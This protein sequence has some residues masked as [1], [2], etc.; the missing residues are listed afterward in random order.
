[1]KLAISQMNSRAGNFAATV[2][3]MV[4]QSRIAQNA[5]ARCMLFPFCVL[6]G[7]S[8]GAWGENEAYVQ[9]LMLA[10]SRLAERLSVPAL[11]PVVFNVMGTSVNELFYIAG[12]RATPVRFPQEPEVAEGHV[13]AFAT[14]GPLA[15]QIGDVS[16][17][18]AFTRDDLDA[19]AEL[20]STFDLVVYFQTEG[21]CVDDP[22]SR[23]APAVA[24]GAY[25]RDASQLNAWFVAVGP[26]G[27]YDEC[28]YTGG[29]F[30]MAPWG[31]LAA[32][33]P[34]FEEDF[35]IVDLAL[36][37]EGPLQNAVQP[38]VVERYSFFWDALVASTRAY[39]QADGKNRAC[40]VALDGSLASAATATM[41]VDAV[42][43]TLVHP[44]IVDN[45]DAAALADARAL[46]RN[47][48]LEATELSLAELA[49]AAHSFA[50]NPEDVSVQESLIAARMSMFAAEHQAL[51][52]SC[53]D[54]TA[55][56]LELEP[57]GWSGG[58]FAPFGDVYRCDVRRLA[59]ARARRSSSVPSSS[60]SRQHAT[61]LVGANFAGT[62]EQQRINAIDAALLMHVEFSQGVES[63]IASGN[64]HI[65]VESLLERLRAC[66]VA[67]RSCPAFPAVSSR[68]VKEAALPVDFAW[69]DHVRGYR[70]RLE[71]EEAFRKLSAQA[72]ADEGE[73]RPQDIAERVNAIRDMLQDMAATDAFEAGDANAAPGDTNEYGTWGSELFSD[74]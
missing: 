33:F 41:L 48:R 68:T 26:V 9:D 27:G 4:V 2:D 39:V 52:I 70:E 34:S 28:V 66:E 45:G 44:L 60:F 54:K 23:L 42:G 69:S 63:L 24:E 50:T 72:P 14:E 29:S 3:R 17:V 65:L 56:A 6:T 32:A 1:M 21:F 53:A 31:E 46:A 30:V 18:A 13:E 38:P 43:P 49:R 7:P 73:P 36:D 67:R 40:V 10:L 5:G 35:Q 62:N 64:N 58:V 12:G 16:M 74:N 19:A 22:D 11:V 71:I 59:E 37:S 8:V 61:K 15:F 57:N 20:P 47:L 25:V 55:L 51:V